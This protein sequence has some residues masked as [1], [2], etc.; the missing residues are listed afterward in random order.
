MSTQCKPSHPTACLPLRFAQRVWHKDIDSGNRPSPPLPDKPLETAELAALVPQAGRRKI[1][2]RFE[3]RNPKHW[4]APIPDRCAMSRIALPIVLVAALTTVGCDGAPTNP[5]IVGPATDV[6]DGSGIRAEFSA[7]PAGAGQRWTGHRV[8][9]ATMVTQVDPNE[10]EPYIMLTGPIMVPPAPAE[11][12]KFGQLMVGTTVTIEADVVAPA[13]GA[14]LM[15]SA[16][17]LVP[18]GQ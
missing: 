4:F 14:P 2:F 7:D 11:S 12:A 18:P 5:V 17:T 13:A 3:R 1:S 9:I 6:G 10:G 8:R 16:A 15:L